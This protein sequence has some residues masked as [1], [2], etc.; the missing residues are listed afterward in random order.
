MGFLVIKASLS[1]CASVDSVSSARVANK[2]Y[3]DAPN[4]NGKR[5]RVRKAN[6]IRE[7]I[8]V[9]L[10]EVATDKVISQSTTHHE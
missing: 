2:N 1:A 3:M 9:L 8:T 10:E 4:A 6:Y 7:E 5:K